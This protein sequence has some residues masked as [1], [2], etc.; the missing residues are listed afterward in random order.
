MGAYYLGAGIIQGAGEP[1][2]L[3]DLMILKRELSLKRAGDVQELDV[4]AMALRSI[5]N[6]NKT[7]EET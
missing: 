7:S 6:S 5:L 4:E 1:L 3:K 2:W